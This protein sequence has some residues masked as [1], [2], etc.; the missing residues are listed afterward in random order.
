MVVFHRKDY[1]IKPGDRMKVMRLDANEFIHRF[2]HHGFLASA[3]SIR[4]VARIEDMST[5]VDPEMLNPNPPFTLRQPCPDC[6]GQMRII[7]TFR[8]GWC[9]T[10]RAPPKSEAA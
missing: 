7:E 10:T 6:G 8:R 9:P 2:R 1:R 5:R 3:N 4:S